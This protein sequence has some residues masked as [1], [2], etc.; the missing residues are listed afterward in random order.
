MTIDDTILIH[1]LDGKLPDDAKAEVENWLA[2]SVENGK[3]AEELYLMLQMTERLRVMRAV[4]VEKALDDFRAKTKKGQ[5]RRIRSG[6][7]W[8]AFQRIAAI[9][10]IPLFLF[11][12]YVYMRHDD[13][14]LQTVEVHT[15]PGVI[16]AFDL[17]DGSKVWL[18]SGSSMKYA[19][20]PKTGKRWV[21]LNGEGY[22]EVAKH[23]G[24]PF[25]VQADS[26]CLLEVTG[27]SFNVCAYADEDV[28][29]TTLTEGSVKLNILYGNGKRAVRELK[30]DEK[31]GY[32]KHSGITHLST[33]HAVSGAA[34][35]SGEVV[36][37]HTPMDQVL[38][39]LGRH[40]NV[41][42]EVKDPEVYH[43]MITL[44][45]KEEPLSQIM[46]YLKTASG[47]HYTIHQPVVNS[48]DT[49]EKQT[50]EITK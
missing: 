46:D 30:P 48:L 24:R 4:D 17:P 22:F 23:R 9:L 8:P 42:F 10:F 41:R 5:N 1:Y 26:S 18:N 12:G 11:A 32:E 15:S 2:A 44:R 50:I 39:T 31:A 37:R 38:R 34:W 43:A 28:I 16:S 19:M 21:E 33:V 13:G 14:G 36:F 27:T 29:E 49:L 7:L 35:R 6:R 45:F 40:Y 3:R 47:I 20:R 25:V